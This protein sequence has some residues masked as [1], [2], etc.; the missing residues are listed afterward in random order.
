MSADDIIYRDQNTGEE[1]HR[2][3]QAGDD[4]YVDVAIPTILNTYTGPSITEYQPN[5]FEKIRDS[6]FAGSVLYGLA[7]DASMVVQ[8]MNPFDMNTNHLSGEYASKD[9]YTMALVN[10]TASALPVGKMTSTAPQGVKVLNKLNAAEFSKKFKGT[11]LARATASTRG[12]VNRM[13][14]KVTGRVNELV[15]SGK[16][17]FTGTKVAG[18]KHNQEDSN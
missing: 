13:M 4:V 8:R 18:K 1:V 15:G 7:D 12:F 17:L 14:N 2:I 6:G 5:N 3:E 11:A 10:T 9:E 16:V